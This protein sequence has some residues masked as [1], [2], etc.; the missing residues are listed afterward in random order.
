MQSMV[1]NGVLDFPLL[2]IFQVILSLY[3]FRKSYYFFF[4]VVT[5]YMVLLIHFVVSIKILYL[6]LTK[7]SYIE[8]WFLKHKDDQLVVTC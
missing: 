1:F 5:I 8:D 3:A 6:V 7:I 4:Q 2:L